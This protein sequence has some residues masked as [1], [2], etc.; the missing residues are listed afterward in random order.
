M[1]RVRV[2]VRVCVC[3]RVR[4]YVCVCVRVCVCACVCVC[5][6]QRSL[7]K[8]LDADFACVYRVVEASQEGLHARNADN[9]STLLLQVLFHIVLG[10]KKTSSFCFST[11]V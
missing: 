4:L 10:L 6:P 2:R 3:V 1:V 9:K 7:R 11:C 5:N 8:L